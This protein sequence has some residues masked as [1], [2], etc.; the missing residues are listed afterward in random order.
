MGEEYFEKVKKLL[1]AENAVEAL[2]FI[3]EAELGKKP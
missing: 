3:R 2:N 1:E